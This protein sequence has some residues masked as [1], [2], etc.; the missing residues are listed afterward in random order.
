MKRR[1]IV[2][3]HEASA[4]AKGAGQCM[5]NGQW[6][7]GNGEWAMGNG[8]WAHSVWNAKQLAGANGD[9]HILILWILRVRHHGVFRD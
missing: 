7:M 2:P 3:G 4:L 6:G 5:G 8:Q 9:K 1:L